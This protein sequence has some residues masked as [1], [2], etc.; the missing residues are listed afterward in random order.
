MSQ[1]LVDISTH[2]LILAVASLVIGY[3]LYKTVGQDRPGSSRFLIPI[4]SL[5]EWMRFI[6]YPMWFAILI[7]QGYWL[8]IWW[9]NALSCTLLIV[10]SLTTWKWF[11]P[12]KQ[13]GIIILSA[14]ILFSCLNYF[15]IEH[16]RIY[17]LIA[18]ALSSGIILKLKG[19]VFDEGKYNSKQ[20][21]FRKQTIQQF[22]KNKTAKWSLNMLIFLAFIAV[23]SDLIANQ[24]PVYA[25]VNKE[26]HYPIYEH[27]IDPMA[28][29]KYDGKDIPFDQ[30]DWRLNSDKVVWTLIPYSP[31][32]QDNYN[33]NFKGPNDRQ[34]YKNKKGTLEPVSGKFRHKLG[35]D[36]T[37]RDVSSGL[38]HAAKISL[39]VGFI[40]MGIAA[41]LG[42][43]LG[44]LGGY[45]G[46][47]S[48]RAH[49]GTFIMVI[50]GVFLGYFY[51]FVALEWQITEAMDHDKS[52]T[53]W[54]ILK[55]MIFCGM[56]FLFW[57]LSRFINKLPLLKKTYYV[58]VDSIIMRSIELL[59]SVPRLLLILVL[60]ATFEEKS[61][62]L[63]MIIIGLTSWTG[64]ARFTRAE[65]LRIRELNYIESA[66][67]MGY[68]NF[69]IILRHILPNAMAPVFVSIAFG[70]AA[71]ILI[72]SSLSF[73]NIGV[74]D[75]VVTWGSMLN[76]AKQNWEASWMV[77]FPGLAIF[78]TIT[79]YN[80]IGEGL[81]DALDPKLKK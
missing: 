8:P 57:Y 64:I 1:F 71:A 19:L 53:L 28:S 81:R 70:I 55:F 63:V 76:A 66:Q 62:T 6:K 52:T 37:G 32:Q 50:L 22:N 26:V 2:I 5:F 79:V 72:E 42:I 31:N 30:F 20:F 58:P 59:N 9:V 77:I 43:F 38:I 41:L 78:I 10:A 60:A 12:I 75:D 21:S 54:Y 25:E 13:K 16:H 29:V 48:I 39:T 14:T 44:A 24:K 34:L 7:L 80:L 65:I 4:W 40:S 17:L 51:A 46:N 23:Y 74:P 67:A 68:S 73:L 69:R 3:D 56:P 61:L 36:K 33:R 11:N 18:L 35:T 27:L 49:L 45:Y 15:W 47:H